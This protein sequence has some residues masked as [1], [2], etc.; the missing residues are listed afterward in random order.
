MKLV[1]VMFLAAGLGS[2]IGG[3]L[4]ARFIKH[5][6]APQQA[7]VLVML[8]C[9]LFM[10]LSP[11]VVTVSSVAASLTCASIIVFMHLAWL[12]N[13][14]ALLTDV[15]PQASQGKVFSVVAAGSS[16]GAI[17]MNYFVAGMLTSGSYNTW[18]WIAS[19]LH[20]AVIPMIWF[21][22]YRRRQTPA[23]PALNP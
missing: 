8:G 2:L 23:K 9:A 14:T 21:I 13:I 3:W 11:L 5:G 7:R 6:R 17:A 19:G 1:S 22:F 10:P 15:V 18:F 12:T 16:V 20:L 4:P